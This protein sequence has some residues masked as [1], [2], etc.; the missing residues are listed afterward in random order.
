MA[1]PKHSL[2]PQNL[3]AAQL[4]FVLGW[5][6]NPFSFFHKIKDIFFIFTNTF[7]DLDILTMLAISCYQLLVG[8]GQGCC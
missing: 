1:G 4:L 3:P 2:S 8:R 6:K 7:I 5:P